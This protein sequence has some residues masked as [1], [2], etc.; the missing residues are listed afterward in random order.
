MTT[1]IALGCG[2]WRDRCEWSRKQG[3]EPGQLPDGH[4]PVD[5]GQCDRAV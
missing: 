3:S 2:A 1:E 5:Q 4:L